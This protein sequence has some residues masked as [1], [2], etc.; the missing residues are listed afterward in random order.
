MLV[1]L[2]VHLLVSDLSHDTSFR[3]NSECRERFDS[4]VLYTVK[5]GPVSDRSGGVVGGYPPIPWV[6]MYT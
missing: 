3:K 1:H 5:L 6:Y 2:S 4:L